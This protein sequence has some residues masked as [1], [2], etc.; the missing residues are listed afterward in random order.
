MTNH[1]TS[2]SA[3]HRWLSKLTKATACRGLFGG[4]LRALGHVGCCYLADPAVMSSGGCKPYNQHNSFKIQHP[5]DSE[6]CEIITVWSSKLLLVQRKSTDTLLKLLKQSLKNGPARE[7]MAFA[8]VL[9]FFTFLIGQCQS[10]G[11][12]HYRDSFST[13]QFCWN[14]YNMQKMKFWCFTVLKLVDC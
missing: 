10:F 1:H 5:R 2:T 6:W 12:V 3:N 11:L 14:S 8:P 9:Q 13:H 4:P 7:H